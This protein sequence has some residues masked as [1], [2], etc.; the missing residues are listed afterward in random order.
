MA[1]R[2][3]AYAVSAVA[4][5]AGSGLAVTSTAFATS[6]ALTEN[7]TLTESVA[8]CYTVKSGS[9]VV[10]ELGGH[11][12]NCSGDNAIMVEN[13]ARVTIRGTGNVN[14]ITSGK[15]AIY[16]N[17]GGKT[18]VE[19]G[20]YNSE[21]WYTVKNL[22][23]MEIR[24]GTFNQGSENTSN[25]SLIDNGWYN[26]KSATGASDQGNAHVGDDL[27][28]MTIT[29][30]TFNHRT[31]TATIKSDDYSQTLIGGGS[32][33]SEKGYLLQASGEVTVN[34][35]TFRGYNSM[36]IFIANGEASFEPGVAVINDGDVEAKYLASV[37]PA[38]VGSG[39]DKGTLTVNGGTFTGLDKILKNGE[40]TIKAVDGTSRMIA[41][42][43]FNIAPADDQMR[44]EMVAAYNADTELYDVVNPEEPAEGT[45]V[46][47]NPETGDWEVVPSE[48]DLADKEDGLI[49]DD[50]APGTVAGSVKFDEPFVAD[51]KAYVS[52]VSNNSELEVVD[53]EPGRKTVLVAAFDIDL[54]DRD[55]VRI[56]VNDVDMTIKIDL[57][58]E[59]YEELAQ[60]ENIEVIYFDEEGVG[61]ESLPAT[62][63]V[64]NDV[65]GEEKYILIF[66]TNHLSTYG[67]AGIEAV[68][69]SEDADVTTPNTGATTKEEGSNS[70]G[71][72]VAAI[73]S[74]LVGLSVTGYLSYR[75]G[76][77]AAKK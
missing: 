34:G 3:F 52:I 60:Y 65:P 35:G 45:D 30:G 57:T 40:S 8:N 71:T 5:A 20:T 75:I 7:L 1:N 32:F 38:Y 6:Q 23:D 18:I 47:Q 48:E 53:S 9:D 28:T 11:D 24:G 2:K 77:R 22:G 27:A 54:Q 49:A 4:M 12:I 50:D 63:R 44:E 70:A 69:E 19:G 43:A 72:I 33:N 59:Q 68:A 76:N 42:G 56:D 31:T 62:I 66:N 41:G 58:K 26:G 36:V 74:I 55:G 16:N 46:E 64:S 51:R 37:E 29:N 10:I 25:A 21:N 39:Y 67:V 14:A 15:A 13:N 61:V 17:I 73:I